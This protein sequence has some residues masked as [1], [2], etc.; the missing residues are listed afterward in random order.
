MQH[1]V[2]GVARNV[3]GALPHPELPGLVRLHDRAPVR[4][5]AGRALCAPSEW[6]L[7]AQS[8]KLSEGRSRFWRAVIGSFRAQRQP[9]SLSDGAETQLVDGAVHP[10]VSGSLVYYLEVDPTTT[11]RKAVGLLDLTSAGGR[12]SPAATSTSITS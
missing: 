2:H 4:E 8:G 1:S 10:A 11:A 7:I 9:A 6:L 5:L 12:W 3:A